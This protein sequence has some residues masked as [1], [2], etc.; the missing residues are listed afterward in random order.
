MTPLRRLRVILLGWFLLAISVPAPAQ[1]R[2]LTIL[3]TNDLHAHLLP[4][5]N[6]RGGFAQVA[7]ILRHETQG[8]TSCL[9]LNAG[10]LVQ[11]TPVSTI[12][13][14]LP[15]YELANLL[16]F[17]AS[18]LGNHEFDYGWKKISEF[19][20][21]AR[22]P[23]VAAN[24][25][26]ENGHL[27]TPQAYVILPVNGI[28][29]AV[30]GALT[31][32]LPNLITPELQG[33]WRVLPVVE[34]VR[35]RAR[36]L[37]QN[38]D[39]I[40]VLGHLTGEEEDALLRE[41]PEVPVIISGH[42][43][44]GLPAP[45][46]LDGRLVVRV[47]A[48]GKEI[49]RLDLQIDVAKKVVAK[50]SWKAIPVMAGAVP[51]AEDVARA[52]AQWED[53][54]SKI[55]DVPIATSER[56]YN[57][58]EALQPLLE[59][60]MAEEMGTDL[61]FVNIGGIRDALPSGTILARHIWNIMPFDNKIVVG[62]FRGDQLPAAIASRYR[63]E[64]DRQYTLATFDFVATNQRSELGVTGLQFPTQT[65]R[66]ARDIFIDWFRKQKVIK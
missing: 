50:S 51:P 19:L 61:A 27:L 21:T 63:V 62:K 29:V 36:E 43:H 52:V 57:S 33:P 64:P 10:D 54:V 40:L 23:T 11:G 16:N 7:A 4:D 41:V 9:I 13:H 56:A 20:S 55:V 66:L 6:R 26:D 12:Y 44:A 14:G 28:R 37:R 48:Y 32:D 8:C 2:S 47:K 30:I 53:K 5:T 34:A 65:A 45:K 31:A 38:S 35:K 60:A 46:Q 49:G 25:E 17:D 15:I 58:R 18:V 1:L 24:V 59:R 42:T 22:F 39:L 3:H